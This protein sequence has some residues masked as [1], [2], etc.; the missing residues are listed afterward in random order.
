[1]ATK[2]LRIPLIIDANGKWA[3]QG[4]TYL[5]KKDEEPDWSFMDEMADTDNPLVCPQRK[6][7]TVNV[8]LPEIEEVAGTS[9]RG[10]DPRE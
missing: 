9:Q 1:M 2:T 8:A 3:A 6:W 7:I 10:P 4:A 5:E